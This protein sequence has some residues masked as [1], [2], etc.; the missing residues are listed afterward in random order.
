MKETDKSGP[1]GSLRNSLVR[2]AAGML[3]L[4]AA[5]ILGL[6]GKTSTPAAAK[7]YGK[8][9]VEVSVTVRESE[10]EG[11]HRYRAKG[12]LSDR[13]TF[14]QEITADANGI[15]TLYVD[16]VCAEATCLYEDYNL[17]SGERWSS[18]ELQ[19]IRLGL[20]AIESIENIQTGDER[21]AFS[22]AEGKFSFAG[23]GDDDYWGDKRYIEFE[24]V[25]KT[26]NVSFTMAGG[27][28]GTV[29]APS[30]DTIRIPVTD[31]ISAFESGEKGFPEGKTV[32]SIGGNSV[33]SLGGF[34]EIPFEAQKENYGPYEVVTSN[35]VKNIGYNGVC[36]HVEVET[37][38]AGV[39]IW[40]ANVKKEAGTKLRCDGEEE[41]FWST[42]SRRAE[43]GRYVAYIMLSSGEEDESFKIAEGKGAYIYISAVDPY[44]GEAGKTKKLFEPTFIV[45]PTEYKK[46]TPILNYA[47]ASIDDCEQPALS[48]VTV[49]KSDG[50]V[51]EYSPAK[52]EKEFKD[53]LSKMSY[54]YLWTE[55]KEKWTEE[56]GTGAYEIS[57]WR[58]T[59]GEH[60]ESIIAAGMPSNDFLGGTEDEI[61]FVYGGDGIEDWTLERT[62]SMGTKRYYRYDAYTGEEPDDRT[63]ISLSGS[64][65]QYEEFGEEIEL[66]PEDQ[67]INQISSR[68]VNYVTR[69]VDPENLTGNELTETTQ[70]T[71]VGEPDSDNNAAKFKATV[72]VNGREKEVSLDDYGIWIYGNFYD[73]YKLLVTVNEA[74]K[75]KDFAI[76][77]RYA[78]GF[79][80]ENAGLV[81]GKSRI[82]YK[83]VY[84]Y[85]ALSSDMLANSLMSVTESSYD[86]GSK[87]KLSLVISLGDQ[88]PGS[89]GKYH[90]R[91]K[92][93]KI[94]IKA[95]PKQVKAKYDI[96]KDMIVIKNGQDYNS[97]DGWKTVLPYSNDGTAKN[98]VIDTKKY[99]PVKKVNENPDM[100]TNE[101]FTG[102]K[103]DD[104]VSNKTVTITLRK[105]AGV[106]K[107]ASQTDDFDKLTCE[108]TLKPRADAPVSTLKDNGTLGIA[109]AKGAIILP[110]VKK[111]ETDTTEAKGFEYIIIDKAD[112]EAELKKPGTLDTSSFMWS[113]YASGKKITL[114]K[115]KSKYKLSSEEGK[116]TDHTLTAGSYILIRRKADK[117][118]KDPYS[119]VLASKNAV[120]RVEE[121]TINTEKKTALTV[122]D[123]VVSAP[124]DAK[125]FEKHHYK[126]FLESDTWLNAKQ[127]CERM[128]GHLVCIASEAEQNFVTGLYEGESGLWIGGHCD[129]E[130]KWA[131]VSGETWDYTKWKEE[132]PSGGDEDCAAIWPQEW[133]DMVSDNRDEQEGFICEWDN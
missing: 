43:D 44:D 20:N 80:S 118:K 58:Y 4:F 77:T 132:E 50:T 107:A 29:K 113:K 1:A 52:N 111:A 48:S 42:C 54:S 127:K 56:D 9:T 38:I 45:E 46:I 131:W 85:Y 19:K 23:V 31:V 119:P 124:S 95:Q 68:Y 65:L 63:K 82:A 112:Y 40:Y 53:L 122:V 7:A 130:G 74:D 79:T 90:R 103:A 110:S 78:A 71:Y 86:K 18:P 32:T 13:Y 11:K 129:E 133:N 101:K 15:A 59:L 27:Y 121:I 26:V 120:L 35:A 55:G 92:S 39:E 10:S 73:G 47:G 114:E 17:W 75:A 115:T 91:S 70:F 100:F 76:D 6:A 102:I 25:P 3:L 94:P 125:A 5:V 2:A 117:N 126:V 116:G 69:L 60:P 61:A 51:E 37:T 24:V 123:M 87:M 12:S 67:E 66:A 128:G 41:N 34:F 99:A 30:C 109:D 97:G 93:V 22:A 57:S 83:K 105:S 49:K 33:N 72:T 14:T 106:S 64:Y 84:G 21:I 104:I 98:A 108:I 81:E 36:D 62:E 28:K 96:K 16:K 89:D 8:A 88:K